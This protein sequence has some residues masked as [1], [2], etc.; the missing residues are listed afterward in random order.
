MREHINNL[1]ENGKVNVAIYINSK[2]EGALLNISS[3]NNNHFKVKGQI[4]IDLYSCLLFQT[5]KP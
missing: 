3:V 4:A 1:I 5:I 2:E